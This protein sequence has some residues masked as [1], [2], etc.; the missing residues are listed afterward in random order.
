MESSLKCEDITKSFGGLIALDGVDFEI[1]DEIVG[2]IGPNGAGKT[3]LF[4]V[5]TGVFSPDEG[6][7]YIDDEA[8]TDWPMYRI[9]RRGVARTFQTPKPIQNLTVEENLR[10]A[11]HF[12]DV[13]TDRTAPFGVAE[14]LDL[15]DLAD[16]ADQVPAAMTLIEKK[17]LEVA[18]G[19]LTNPLFFMLDE[20]MAGLN[21]SEKERI[22]SKL[23]KLY[24]E[25][26]VSLFVIEHDLA[27][28]RSLSDRVIVLNN[29]AVLDAGNPEM[30]LANEAVQEAYVGTNV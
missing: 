14:I 15:F 21:P 26:D 4:N 3:T 7:V 30:V 25:Y 29:G 12:G 27:A 2:L 16:Y 24:E 9:A 8:V 19:A 23:R 20:V 11:Q 6:E 22:T 1:E 17:F 18:K 10:V 13:G 5:I 28:I